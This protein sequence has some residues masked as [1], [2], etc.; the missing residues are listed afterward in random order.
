MRDRQA[1]LAEVAPS[2]EPFL[3]DLPDLDA[4]VCHE[5][6]P[7]GWRGLTEQGEVLEVK[8]PATGPFY[9]P[10]SIIV[11]CEGR[12]LG[13]RAIR[14]DVKV[15]IDD[16]LKHFNRA[17]ECCQTNRLGEA[18][19]EAQI[20]VGIVA[21]ERAKFNRGMILLAAGRWREG[22]AQYWDCEQKLPF[23]R[24]QV[25]EAL[26]RGERPWLG[27]DLKG[28]KL[29]LRHCHGFGDSLQMLRYVP[30]LQEAGAEVVL[31]VPTELAQ[32]ARQL[33]PLGTSGDFFCPI[34]HLL[35]FLPITPQTVSGEPYLRVSTPPVQVEG[36]RRIGLAWSVGKP[37]DG[38]F[39]RE[40][41]L[42]LLVKAFP[43]AE[44][45]SVQTQ[46]ADEARALGVHVHEFED[47]A[48]CA[49]F[50]TLMDQ[51]VSVDTA[52]LHLAGAIG[53]PKVT[54]LLSYWS[55]WRWI[56]PWYDNVRLCRQSKEEDWES[57]LAQM[58]S[59]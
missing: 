32:L 23:K 35:H 8:R 33:A 1:S 20:T 51:V 41:P 44:L 2:C 17:V 56:A 52:A 15:D 58:Q 29:C 10:D 57:A 40:I 43:G 53:H 48:S 11:A 7:Y 18:L 27:E 39:P 38:D 21:T 13:R 24:P 42:E 19:I 3:D 28:R 31:D 47:F 36:R 25:V 5:M 30:T 45:H 9:V 12:P 46:K 55:S 59:C 22:F 50:M 16:Y 26:A 14:N 37:C 34:L 49:R 54:G 6:T 4:V